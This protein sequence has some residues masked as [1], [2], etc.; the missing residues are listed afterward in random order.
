MKKYLAVIPMRGGST[1][2]PGKHLRDI[3]GET[4]AAKTIRQ[5]VDEIGSECDVL[6]TT[7][8]NV[9]ADHCSRLGALVHRRGDE[10]SNNT[11]STESVL[12]VIAQVFRAYKGIYLS[13]CELSRWDGALS[14]LVNCHMAEVCDS[15]FFVERIAKKIWTQTNGKFKILSQCSGSTC[16]VKPSIK[17]VYLWNI[18]V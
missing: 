14:E 7:D 8:S 1:G 16:H 12:K 6:V 11:A 4:V 5:V 3:C 10:L 15:T 13:A 9:I 18:Q 17:T 2:L